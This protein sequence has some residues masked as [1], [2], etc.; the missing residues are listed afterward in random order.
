MVT[1]HVGLPGEGKVLCQLRAHGMGEDIWR[2]VHAQWHSL[3]TLQPHPGLVI[4]SQG[5]SMQVLHP[6]PPLLS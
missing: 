2:P 4:T 5:L 6:R 3:A 1:V